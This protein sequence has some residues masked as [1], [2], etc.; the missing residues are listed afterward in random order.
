MG[1][2]KF[3]FKRDKSLEEELK[4]TTFTIYIL[5]FLTLPVAILAALLSGGN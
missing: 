1:V 4:L 5:M 3:I 2:V